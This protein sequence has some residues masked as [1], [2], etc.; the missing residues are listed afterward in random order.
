MVDFIQHFNLTA[1]SQVVI[2]VLE[3]I[4]HTAR[5]LL[6]LFVWGC[7][8]AGLILLKRSGTASKEDVWGLVKMVIFS[9]ILAVCT[10]FLYAFAMRDMVLVSG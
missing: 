3:A 1:T 7:S 5:L 6:A 9:S 10:V 2:V 4:F 8:L